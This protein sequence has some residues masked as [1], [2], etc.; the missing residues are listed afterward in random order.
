MTGFPVPLRHNKPNTPKRGLRMA[1]SANS[2]LLIVYRNHY[3]P[4][5]W[6][7]QLQACY[8]LGEQEQPVP[9]SRGRG[10]HSPT[11]HEL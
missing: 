6:F 1:C 7:L 5:E 2:V 10:N 4:L 9:C 3:M 8:V 11:P